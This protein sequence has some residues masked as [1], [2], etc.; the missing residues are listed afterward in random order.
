MITASNSLV[1]VKIFEDGIQPATFEESVPSVDGTS[2]WNLI[3]NHIQSNSSTNSNRKRIKIL[4]ATRELVE[5]SQNLIDENWLFHLH[6]E[7]RTKSTLD[8]PKIS[9]IM[10]TTG[11]RNRQL[12]RALISLVN[13]KFKNFE[14]V[15]VLS[16]TS[17]LEYEKFLAFFNGLWFKSEISMEVVWCDAVGRVAPLN[18]GLLCAVGCYAT[19]LDD[20]DFALSN[21]LDNYSEAAINTKLPSV[22]RQQIACANSSSD[23]KSQHID[24]Q[25]KIVQ[26]V[27][28]FTF[29]YCRPWSF[30]KT[31]KEN[32]TP[33]MGMAVPRSRGDSQK[34][35]FFD[36]NIELAEDWDFLLANCIR[37]PLVDIS[38]IGAVY[39]RLELNSREIDRQEEWDFSFHYVRR[40]IEST[41]VQL[42]SGWLSDYLQSFTQDGLDASHAKQIED[43]NNEATNRLIQEI[44]EL[45]N[46]LAVKEEERSATE[47]ARRMTENELRKVLRRSPSLFIRKNSTWRSL[48]KENGNE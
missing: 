8:N 11:K 46:Q 18:A 17:R 3:Q 14:V 12:E 31:L 15:I 34:S 37:Y 13:Q 42:S 21:W 5:K 36:S 16:S 48:F 10:R 23:L 9:V 1:S 43:R 2:V 40:K 32:F 44:S 26:Q 30:F 47:N 41:G 35:L 19:F 28:N 45:E 4:K 24:G 38:E 33:I 22:L 29:E 6:L 27:D 20:D 25:V 39:N 7:N